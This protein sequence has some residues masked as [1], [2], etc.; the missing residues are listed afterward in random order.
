[1]IR[2]NA[3]TSKYRKVIEMLKLSQERNAA[4]P[5]ELIEQCKNAH[6][7]IIRLPAKD[8]RLRGLAVSPTL[9]EQ[10][11]YKPGEF[12]DIFEVSDFS[13]DPNTHSGNLKIDISLC[14]AANYLEIDAE[15][16]DLDSKTVV[17]QV[18]VS[19]DEHTTRLV[20]QYDFAVEKGVSDHLG[21]MTWGKWG[22][23]QVYENELVIF[24]QANNPASSM[25]YRHIQPK[26]E[27]DPVVL[28][29][30]ENFD[31]EVV[32]QGDN[33]HIVIALIRRPE[34]A[35]DVDYICGSG[36]DRYNHPILCVPGKGEIVIPSDETPDLEQ[37]E[38]WCRL[39][40]GTGGAA[41]IAAVN[42][43]G[44][45]DYELP[46]INLKYR[47]NLVTYSFL[48]WGV[49]YQDK[50]GWEKTEF[51]Y[52]LYLHLVT[53][54]TDGKTS[55]YELYVKSS[56]GGK[57]SDDGKMVEWI[58]KLQIM[59]GCLA[60]DTG[61]LVYEQGADD[62]LVKKEVPICRI[63]LGDKVVGQDGRPLTVCN[64]WSGEEADSMIEMVTH[65]LQTPLR[66]TR[67][68]PVWVQDGQ[69]KTG[70]KRAA[71]CV[72]GDRVWTASGT[73]QAVERVAQTE[74]CGMVYNL[75]LE[76]EENCLRAA[77]SG[78]VLT[79]DQQVQNGEV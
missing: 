55:F 50:G 11:A 64:I 79:G 78:G 33:Q 8:G 62:V 18:P 35:K 63:K 26:K 76:P 6:N 56:E 22:P 20:M 60:P 41:M 27:K 58:P 34:N 10:T 67:S 68:H 46:S 70:W 39:Y 3:D 24:E 54:S 31:P 16:L 69:G 75:E 28:G 12:R 43:E 36:R 23:D 42:P 5:Q 32:G 4:Y 14:E 77:F 1:M 51:D 29:T 73:W 74:S 17:A 53:H 66:M 71:Q 59:Y 65:G 38:G 72:P 45:G 21:V 19:K 47:N 13:Y 9:L 61:I 57:S 37:S 49:G 48:S 40:R 15:I 2:L 7:Q 25:Q 30:L 44:E 52:S